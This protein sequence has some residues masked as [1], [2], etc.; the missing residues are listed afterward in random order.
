MLYE[1]YTSLVTKK[2]IGQ[3]LMEEKH[4][5]YSALCLGVMD[6][7]AGSLGKLPVTGQG[8]TARKNFRVFIDV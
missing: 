1:S 6:L 7:A 3:P 5:A 4:K 2:H 8:Y